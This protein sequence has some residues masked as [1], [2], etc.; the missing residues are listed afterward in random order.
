MKSPKISVRNGGV[1]R[2]LE[3][4]DGVHSDSVRRIPGDDE[5]HAGQAER[6]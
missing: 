5:D 1:N 4:D 2:I 6:T 3:D